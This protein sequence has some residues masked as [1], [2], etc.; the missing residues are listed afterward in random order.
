MVWA[1][2]AIDYETASTRRVR[3]VY[4]NFNKETTPGAVV[5]LFRLRT[6][7]EGALVW[8]VEGRVDGKAAFCV[9]MVY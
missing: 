9:K 7:E 8:Y 6:E 5:R 2:D 4:L 3:D 1:M